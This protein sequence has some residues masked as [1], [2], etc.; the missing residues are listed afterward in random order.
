MNALSFYRVGHWCY[1]RRIPVVPRLMYQAICVLYNAVIPMSTEIGEGTEFAYGGIGVVL[2]E[3]C[4]IGKFVTF[5]HQVTVGGRSR[6]WGVPVI[7]DRCVIGA[8]AK[9]LGPISIGTESVIGA[10]AVVLEDVPPRTVVAG[11]PAKVVRTDIDI[12]DYSC[13]QPPEE[14]DALS[15]RS[16]DNLLVTSI[17]DPSQLP[18]LAEE[19]AELLND[20]D[21]DC[22][23]LT[24]EWLETWW[25]HFSTERTLAIT[26]VR[27]HSRLLGLA[28]LFSEHHHLGPRNLHFRRRGFPTA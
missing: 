12:A 4:K 9:L 15:Y 10:N 6:R 17:K 13:L 24:R 27:R 18:H 28:P 2:H 26:T 25:R 3:R 23:F 20:S 14:A 11:I 21:A 7:E 22:L 1:R 5:G 8:G 16:T 19:W